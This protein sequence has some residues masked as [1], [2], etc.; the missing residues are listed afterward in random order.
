VRQ[1]V[2]DARAGVR[3]YSPVFLLMIPLVMSLVMMT[4][5]TTPASA[6]ERTLPPQ[7]R[8]LRAEVCGISIFYRETGPADAPCI[9]LLHG[10]PSSS[11]MFEPLF[12][13]LGAKYRLIAPDYPGFG[14][15]DAPP[16]GNFAYTFDHFAAVIGEFVQALGLKTY[17]LYLQDYGGP[18]G[19]RLAI[20]HP[21]RV[22]ALIIQNAVVHE[23]GLSDV[24]ALRRAYWANRSENEAKII[25]GLYSVSAG[26]ARHVGPRPEVERFN[27]DLWMD[28]INFL[29]RPGEQAIQ[30][31]LIYDYR[32]NVAAYPEWQAYLR[33]KHPTTLVLWGRFDPIFAL[34]GAEAFK[35]E[36]PDAEVHV[37]DAGHFALEE[38][39]PAMAQ[40]IDR[41][42]R[43]KPVDRHHPE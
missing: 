7:I 10:Y 35:R 39:A 3:A 21:E 36:V 40:I 4:S 32:S 41:F 1:G 17:S 15:S 19:L 28:E 42:L 18:V 14:L 13:L 22:Q 27:P 43:S 30:L 33:E 26:I 16:P 24:W 20:A 11:R 25:A 31:S 38:C 9:L 5:A 12:P 37:L 23:E 34:A 6:A 2:A 8:Y 29:M